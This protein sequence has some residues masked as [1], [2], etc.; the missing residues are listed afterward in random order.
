MGEDAKTLGDR[1]ARRSQERMAETGFEASRPSTGDVSSSE[2]PILAG[3]PLELW[4]VIAAFAL[5][6]AW[7]AFEVLKSLPDAFKLLGAQF[8]GFRIGLA[9]II[10]LVLVGLLG[11]G[12]LAIAWKLY[13][14]DRV[15]RGLAYSFATTVAV[16]VLFS[17]DRTSAETGALLLSVAGILILGFGPR[18]RA[19]FD[20]SAAPDG[21]PT[22]VIVSRTIIAIYTATAIL[23]GVTYLLLSTVSA[24]YAVIGL[25]TI[26]GALA[27]IKW[28]RR[29]SSADR[30][31]RQ[32]LSIGAS[33]LVVLMLALGQ[34][35][36]GLLVPVG[37]IVSAIAS[38]WLPADARLFFGDQP[39]GAQR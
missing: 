13:Q 18:V 28:S 31:A 26:G 34:K 23:V 12:M 1:E 33:A 6:G 16:S 17:S 38:L 10:I 29:L 9:L 35:S 27:S 8:V 4:L 37:L 2:L 3:L 11:A 30:Q 21:A 5:P 7:L 15:A 32:Y 14:R 25:I 22:S 20:R 39:L 36:T 24:K 19:I